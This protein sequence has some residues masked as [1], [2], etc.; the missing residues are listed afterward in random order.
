MSSVTSYSCGEQSLSSKV[1]DGVK[2]CL[3]AAQWDPIGQEIEID[4][5]IDIEIGRLIYL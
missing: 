1:L 2:I 5:W 3:G 4:R